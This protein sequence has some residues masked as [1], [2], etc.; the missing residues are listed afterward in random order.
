MEPDY[1]LTDT[2][3]L[4]ALT[5]LAWSGLLALSKRAIQGLEQKIDDN[6][7]KVTALQSAMATMVGDTKYRIE[8]NFRD[9]MDETRAEIKELSGR[10]PKT[11]GM[12]PHQG[13]PVTRREFQLFVTGLNMKIDSIHNQLTKY[14]ANR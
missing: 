8:R 7:R 14:G 9:L 4:M 6:A 2:R 5:A 12:E 3:L 1:L 13:E 11:A 10:L